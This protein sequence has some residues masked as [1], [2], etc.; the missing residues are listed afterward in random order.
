[1][2]SQNY[3][4]L[5]LPSKVEYAFLA[6]LEMASQPDLK[7]PLTV[8]EITA[9]QPIPERYLEQ[10]LASLRRG[11]LLKSQRGSKG[12]YVLAREPQEITLLEIVSIIEGNRQIKENMDVSTVEMKLIQESWQQANQ[13]AQSILE[14]YTL[15]D[16]CKQRESYMQQ[17]L[18][19]YI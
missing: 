9:K 6:L 10:I 4:L 17:S 2:D 1:M 18:M 12:G 11:G 8:N 13:A 7:K 14:K 16:L 19:Y 5:S 15:L 3:I